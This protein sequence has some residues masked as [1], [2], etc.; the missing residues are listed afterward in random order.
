MLSMEQLTFLLF[1]NYD[2]CTQ[3]L[4]IA[5]IVLLHYA[6]FFYFIFIIYYI[7][8]GIVTQYDVLFFFIN[9]YAFYSIELFF[10]VFSLNLGSTLF[11]QKNASIY[12][13][14]LL[15]VHLTHISEE[16]MHP[17]N[18]M[19]YKHHPEELDASKQHLLHFISKRVASRHFQLHSKSNL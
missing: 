15:Y 7:N 10:F 17:T 2:K 19:C 1:S 8:Y 16:S 3:N 6:I 11:K 5:L 12:F 4:I 9:Y 18:S 13:V 14:F